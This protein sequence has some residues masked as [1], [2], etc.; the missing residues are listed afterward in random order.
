[1]IDIAKGRYWDLPWSLVSSCTRCS[2][3]CQN[4]W[5]LAME[6]RFH[7]GIEGKVVTHPDRLDIPLKR[8][9]PT[10]YAVW[11]DLFHEAVPDEFIGET[12]RVMAS[13]QRHTFLIL[14]K[15]PQRMLDIVRRLEAGSLCSYMDGDESGAEW[16]NRTFSEVFP[17]VWPGLT[18][19]N[20]EELDRLWTIFA[21][22]PGKKF[23]SIEP[24]LEAINV[25]KYL[26]SDCADN[27]P[28]ENRCEECC[29]ARMSDFGPRLIDAVILGGETGPG[30]RPMHPEWVR[31]IRDQC[32]AAGVPF[33]FKQWG[34]WAVGES[35][36]FRRYP[37]DIS[38]GQYMVR[39]GRKAAGRLLDGKTYDSLPWVNCHE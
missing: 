9:K 2:P 4:C 11:N 8:K 27:C 12:F 17:N 26:R 36:D 7:K 18:I 21:Q 29:S 33:F 28:A 23:L 31:S 15:R 13:I 5:S 35:K 3:G 14:T 34:E 37:E 19:C 16:V 1:M 38:T 6:K 20:Q 10:V 32:A 39:V 30:A 25:S 22:V 24:M